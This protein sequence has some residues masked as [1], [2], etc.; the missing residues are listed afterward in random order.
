MVDH[1]RFYCQVTAFGQ[2]PL[3]VRGAVLSG[4]QHIAALQRRHRL[5]DIPSGGIRAGKADI[6]DGI[7]R[8]EQIHG[9]GGY[10]IDAVQ[11]L[12][13]RGDVSR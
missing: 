9:G 8:P 4:V 1:G 5:R 7:Q 12:A 13:Q 3:I 11:R 10:Q 6:A 2:N